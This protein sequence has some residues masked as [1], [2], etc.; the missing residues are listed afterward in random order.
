[1]V[2]DMLFFT[3]SLRNQVHMLNVEPGILMFRVHIF[4]LDSRCKSWM[5]TWI[6]CT[7]K[8]LLLNQRKMHLAVASLFLCE[9]FIFLFKYLQYDRQFKDGIYLIVCTSTSLSWFVL[10]PPFLASF[11]PTFNCTFSPIP[12]KVNQREGLDGFQNIYLE[13]ISGNKDMSL[14]TYSFPVSRLCLS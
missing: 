5:F 12:D 14:F 10:S 3:A 7:C 4:N 6:N 8:M 9:V 1:M 13:T 2:C 11:H